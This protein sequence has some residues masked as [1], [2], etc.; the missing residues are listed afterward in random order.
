MDFLLPPRP[1]LKL[2]H[3]EVDDEQ[4][5][6]TVTSTDPVACCG[7]RVKRLQDRFIVTIPAPELSCA[8]PTWQYG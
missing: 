4:L 1:G 8:G 3:L 5:I 6:L 2:T 7:S